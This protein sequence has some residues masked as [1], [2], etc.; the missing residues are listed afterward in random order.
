MEYIINNLDTFIKHCIHTKQHLLQITQLYVNFTASDITE[1][2]CE[3]FYKHVFIPIKDLPIYPL[4]MLHCLSN[5]ISIKSNLQFVNV[6]HVVNYIT[7]VLRLYSDNPRLYEEFWYM[8]ENINEINWLHHFVYNSKFMKF[9]SHWLNVII[10]RK[11]YT[12]EQLDFIY[13]II[14][15]VIFIISKHE[16]LHFYFNQEFGKRVIQYSYTSSLLRTAI[17]KYMNCTLQQQCALVLYN[18]RKITISELDELNIHL[19][20]F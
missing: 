7:Q 17:V 9:F 1:Y 13:K 6:D 8:F 19:Y 3:Y 16:D 4:Y 5:V 12:K 10:A 2:P 15:L 11:I 18:H 14:K 20:I